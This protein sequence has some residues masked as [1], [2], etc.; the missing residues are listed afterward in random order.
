M[1]VEDGV[2]RDSPDRTA[3]DMNNMGFLLYENKFISQ[4]KEP[5]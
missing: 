3:H 4:I 2:S 5:Q 1:C